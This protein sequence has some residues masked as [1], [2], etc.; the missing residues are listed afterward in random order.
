M[1]P[2]LRP[3]ILLL[4]VLAT[5]GCHAPIYGGKSPLA[6]ARMS[7][8]SVGLEMFWVRFPF[9]DPA[10]NEDLWKEIDEH[11]ISPDT[12]ERLARNG[13]RAGVLG[14]Q[15]PIELSKLM[16]LSDKTASAGEGNVVKVEDMQTKPRVMRRY[17]QIRA[18]QPGQ[19]IASS[20]YPDL[21]VLLSR[22]GQISGQNYAQAQ[23]IFAIKS[24][25]QPDGRVR[26]ELVPELH[27]GQPVSR[28]LGTQGV[29]HL[30]AN[31]PKQPYD[32]LTVAADLQPGSML[33]LGCLSNRPGSLGHHFF[34]ENNGSLE[35]KLLVI[36]LAHTQSDGLF[37]PP[38]PLK[39]EE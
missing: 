25:P 13:F 20:I 35:Q 9:G 1:L 30:E 11:P 22:S 36:R 17:L 18:G 34:T 15:L 21:T 5:A 3:A 29:I 33:V 37:I 2:M 23:G 8:D 26:L 38:E 27:Y 10:A 31:K 4:A 19:I 12:R 39:I 16:E 7:P 14:S 28:Y 24:F 32:E 6:P